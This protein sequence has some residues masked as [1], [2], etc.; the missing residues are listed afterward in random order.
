[1]AQVLKDEVREAIC[2]AALEVFTERG[3]KSATMADLAAVAGVSTGN[4]Y[5][6]FESKE[7]LYHALVPDE[8]V[9]TLRRLLR[10]RVQ[11]LEGV[12]DPRR[13]GPE[14]TYHVLSR[15]LL[16]F[17]VEHRRQVV[18][19]LARSEGAAHEG[20]ADETVAALLKLAVAHF[21]ARA[22]GLRLDPVTR[23]VLARVYRNLVDAVVQILS[24][25][26]DEASVRRAVEV[27]SRY[28]LAGLAGLFAEGTAQVR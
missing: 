7:V 20:F 14:A 9:D 12:D 23:L 17:V 15:E 6:Y 3:F 1:M 27:Y 10:Q 13:L 28:H 25:L 2:E 24:E 19:L 18:L 16:A 4:I 11:A 5:R 22:P 26:E 21:R 8:L